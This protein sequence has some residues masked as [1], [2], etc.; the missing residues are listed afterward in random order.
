MSWPRGDTRR[1]A[2]ST[3][4]ALRPATALRGVRWL[5]AAE[6]TTTR[7]VAQATGTYALSD[8]SG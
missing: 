3:F 4:N 8:V 6:A 7:L 5:F 1:T 2:H